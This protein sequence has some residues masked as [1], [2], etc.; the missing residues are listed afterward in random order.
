MSLK[1]LLSFRNIIIP[2][3]VIVCAILYHEDLTL[4]FNTFKTEVKT[5]VYS[6]QELAQF[7]GIEKS[8][9]YLAV[10]GVVFDVTKGKKYYEKGS[11]YHYFVGKDGSRALVT[12]DFKDESQDKD[13]VMDLS[14]NELSTVLH[15]RNTFEKKYDEIGILSGRFYDNN[16]DETAYTRELKNKLKQC[17]LEKA[18]TKEENLKYP[19]CN[20]AWSEAEGTK[21]W[22][23]TS[24]GGIRRSWTGVP[25]QLYSPGVDKPRC[26]CLNLNDKTTSSRL[27]T[28]YKNCPET[29]TTCFIMT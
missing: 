11:G 26:I 19:P 28:E 21:V 14:C 29:A 20:I 8:N 25:R 7:N 22:C 17:D 2:V 5:G 27:I 24:S 13:H 4:Y 12:G 18:N 3:A 6:E 16:G 1:Y 15:W 10:L 9:L 23:T